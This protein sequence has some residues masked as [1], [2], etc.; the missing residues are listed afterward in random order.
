MLWVY[1]LKLRPLN[2]LYQAK[3]RAQFSVG[4]KVVVTTENGQEIGKVIREVEEIETSVDDETQVDIL[5]LAT[6]EDL[7]NLEKI[8]QDEERAFETAKAKI[9]EHNLEMRL[10]KAKISLDRQKIIFYFSAEDRVDFR[11][12]VKDL[13][14]IYKTRIEMRQIGTRDKARLVG[15]LGTCGQRL[16]C[17]GFLSSFEPVSIKMAKVQDLSLNPQKI[18]GACGRLMCCLRYEYQVYEEFKQKAPKKGQLVQTCQGA[19]GEVVEFNV[20]RQQV[21]FKDDQGCKH[22]VNVSEVKPVTKRPK[23]PDSEVKGA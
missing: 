15:G 4:D 13:A 5:R 7:S 12:L 2:C 11:L 20:L 21:T 19:C 6:A 10:V 16:C 23:M 8:H 22:Q 3:S 9:A 14:A 18:S 1:E 17:A